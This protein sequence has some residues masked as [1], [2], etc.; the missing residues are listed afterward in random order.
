M[1]GDGGCVEHPSQAAAGSV[2]GAGGAGVRG[3]LTWT[4]TSKWPM[5]YRRGYV[6][7]AP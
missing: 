7:E 2:A 4:A 1:A 6:Q 3:G 5:E